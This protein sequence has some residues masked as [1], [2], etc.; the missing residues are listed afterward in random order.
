[1]RADATGR[2]RIIEVNGIPGLKPVTSWSPQLFSMYYGSGAGA[3]EDYRR[4][5]DMIVNSGLR[6]YGLN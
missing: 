6:R 3:A 2:L 5:I 4:L 1:M